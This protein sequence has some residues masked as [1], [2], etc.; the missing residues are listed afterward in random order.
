MKKRTII[1][2]AIDWSNKQAG[3]NKYVVHIKCDKKMFC[4]LSPSLLYTLSKE[5]IIAKQKQLLGD[6]LTK[7]ESIITYQQIISY[8]QIISHQQIISQQQIILLYI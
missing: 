1:H 6:I 5:T 8:H 3:P 4:M 2:E 7:N